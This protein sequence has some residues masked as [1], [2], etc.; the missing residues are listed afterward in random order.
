MRYRVEVW[1]TWARLALIGL[2]AGILLTPRAVWRERARVGLGLAVLFVI[3]LGL[4][5]IAGGGK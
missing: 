3:L 1:R 2:A 5:M 4:A